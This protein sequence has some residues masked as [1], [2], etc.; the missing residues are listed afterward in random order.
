MIDASKYVKANGLYDPQKPKAPKRPPSE[1]ALIVKQVMAERG[2]KMIDA[3][4]YVKA[5]GLYVAKQ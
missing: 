2:L 3:S 1:R 5:N 4:K